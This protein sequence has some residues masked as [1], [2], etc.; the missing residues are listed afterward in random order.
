MKIFLGTRFLGSSENLDSASRHLFSKEIRKSEQQ[1]DKDDDEKVDESNRVEVSDV[2]RPG[3][4][5]GPTCILV[6]PSKTY[7]ETREFFNW[8]GT[9]RYQKTGSKRSLSVLK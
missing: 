5:S 6:F 2:V 1:E 8:K 9:F 3:K 7:C 4:N